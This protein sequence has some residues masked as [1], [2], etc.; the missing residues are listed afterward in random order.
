MRYLF[1]IPF[2][3][4]ALMVGCI[5]NDTGFKNNTIVGKADSANFTIIAWLDTA[6]SFGKIIEGEKIPV[7]FRFKNTGEKPLVIIDT[8]ASCGCTIVDKPQKPFAPGE[9]GE[10]KAIYNS[11]GHMGVQNKSITVTSNTPSNEE[12]KFSLEVIKKS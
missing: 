6:K 11:E 3:C 7:T 2:A 1:L 8:H 9:E 12:L 5:N 10:I 4:M